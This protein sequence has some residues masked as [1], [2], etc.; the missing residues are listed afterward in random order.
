MAHLL[1]NRRG[2]A[3]FVGIQLVLTACAGSDV[4]QVAKVGEQGTIVQC[5]AA[6]GAASANFKPGATA[7][8]APTVDGN[9]QGGVVIGKQQ[10][11]GAKGAQV[12]QIAQAGGKCPEGFVPK[13]Q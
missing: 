4:A 11:E 1:T 2:G 3:A 7:P 9:A 12:V 5:I 6:T 8:G 13:S 10:A